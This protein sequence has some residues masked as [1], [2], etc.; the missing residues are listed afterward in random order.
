LFENFLRFCGH[1]HDVYYT[2]RAKG[3]TIFVKDWYLRIIEDERLLR[4]GE[5]SQGVT[6]RKTE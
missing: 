1:D 6:F 4:G 2:F 5:K 3:V